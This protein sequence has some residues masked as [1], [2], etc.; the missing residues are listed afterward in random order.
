MKPRVY[1]ASKLKHVRSWKMHRNT[2]TDIDFTSR[3]LDMV[4]GTEQEAGTSERERFARAWV[5]DIDDVRKSDFL[6]I[7]A[8]KDEHLRGALVEAGAALAW[9]VKVI[10]ISEHEDYGTWQNHPLCYHETN[11]PTALINITNGLYQ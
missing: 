1:I 7:Y 2:F 5:I 10:V 6:I 8:A 3:W 9:G 11:V 4:D